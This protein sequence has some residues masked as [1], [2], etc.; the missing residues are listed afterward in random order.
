[1]NEE[2]LG[3][4]GRFVL[5]LWRMR[6]TSSV[7]MFVVTF[8]LTDTVGHFRRSGPYASLILLVGFGFLALSLLIFLQRLLTMIPPAALGPALEET[9]RYAVLVALNLII[10]NLLAPVAELLSFLPVTP[11]IKVILLAISRLSGQLLFGLFVAGIGLLALLVLVRILDRVVLRTPAARQVARAIH[12]G[13]IGALALYG[14]YGVVLA[15][16]GSLDTGA[17]TEHR[18]EVLRMRGW[19]PMMQWAELRGWEAGQPTS[20]VYVFPGRDGFQMTRPMVG[21]PVIVR[22][23]PGLLGIP[24]VD[25]MRPDPSYQA[26]AILQ[27]APTAGR[28][29]REL[30]LRLIHNGQWADALA[31]TTIHHQQYP[32]DRTG[33]TAIVDA[34]RAASRAGEVSRLE[35][36]MREAG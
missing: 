31:Q 34:F 16:N 13:A 2:R 8:F 19:P 18:T 26:E 23:R 12:R 10:L 7:L 1:M 33:L 5:R 25:T 27:A 17:A 22:I 11:L 9:E 20:R 28:V 24:W 29:R 30:I 3:P 14:L 32:H 4:L 6:V 21:Q 35:E 36:L 15:Y